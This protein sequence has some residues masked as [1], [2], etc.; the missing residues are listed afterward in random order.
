MLS[1]SLL[2]ERLRVSVGRLARR[3][4]Q[5]SL[6]GLT[7]SQASVLATLDNH[8]SMSMSRIAEHEAISRPSATGIVGRLA[9][10]GLVERSPDPGDLRSAIV[11]ITPQGK[12]LLRQRR[13]ERTAYLARRIE[14]LTDDDREILARAVDIF[15]RLNGDG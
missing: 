14:E 2:A 1:N 13:R 3:L 11:A 15:E 12:A 5:Q 9:E 10:K 7:P 6:G 4:R 8:G